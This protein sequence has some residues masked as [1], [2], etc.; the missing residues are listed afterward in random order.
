[1]K[2]Y[3]LPLVI[4]LLSLSNNFAQ[5][6]NSN[7]KLNYLIGTW[8]GEGSGKPGEGGGE[9]S[10]NYNLDKNIII[11]KSHSEYPAKDNKPNITH[12]DLMVIYLDSNNTLTKAIYFDNEKHIINYSISFPNENEIVFTSEKVENMPVFRLVYSKIE[13]DLM[14]VKFEMSQDGKNFMT[15]IEGKSKRVK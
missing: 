12:D 6:N 13:S 15:Y 1:M 2:K 9:F 5:Q 10:F 8:Q 3:I 14:N 11:R 7:E 4:I